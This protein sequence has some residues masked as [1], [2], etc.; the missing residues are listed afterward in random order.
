MPWPKATVSSRTL[1][2]PAADPRTRY[3]AFS[4]AIRP[5][6]RLRC[7]Q[8]CSATMASAAPTGKEGEAKQIATLAGFH[9][10]LVIHVG[11]GDGNLTAALRLADN[12]V[13]QG[14]EADAKKVDVARAAI[15]SL[16]LYG[17]VSILRWNAWQHIPPLKKPWIIFHPT[18]PISC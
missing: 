11:C 9:G 17:P 8:T 5:S 4:R 7:S 18:F 3:T 15:R 16:G 10:G 2:F 14:L 12:C 13:V 6:S 1:R